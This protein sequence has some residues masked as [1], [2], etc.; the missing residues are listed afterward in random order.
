MNP[1]D[2][3]P[4]PTTD[5][6]EVVSSQKHSPF[7]VWIFP[8]LAAAAA[9][10]FFFE[11][12][13]S[14]GPAIEVHFGETPGIFE[15]KTK[16]TYRGVESGTVES[17]TLDKELGSVV[18]K[19]RLKK[20][21]AGLATRETIFW[22]DRPVFNLAEMTGIETIVAGNSIQASPPGGPP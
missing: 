3:T 13:E 18:V 7:W 4:S 14:R 22:I 8:I 10:L 15:R 1:D 21:A 16:L 19:I 5:H 12:I 9:G 2:A 6:G 20:F 17:V 11:E